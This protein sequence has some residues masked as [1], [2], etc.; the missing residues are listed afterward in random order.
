MTVKTYPQSFAW[1]VRETHFIM[2]VFRVNRKK[3]WCG[4]NCGVPNLN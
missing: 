1:W 4:L 3:R 2:E